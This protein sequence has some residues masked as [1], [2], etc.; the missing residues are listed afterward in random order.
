[1]LTPGK[2]R[3]RSG[4]REKVQKH[5]PDFLEYY[6]CYSFEVTECKAVRRKFLLVFDQEGFNVTIKNGLFGRSAFVPERFIDLFE[7]V[8]EKEN[9]MREAMNAHEMMVNHLNKIHPNLEEN[10]YAIESSSLG[11]IN[12]GRLRHSV[13]SIL[14]Q[15]VLFKV[16]REGKS[17]YFTNALT[18]QHIG[19]I[20]LDDAITYLGYARKIDLP[21]KNT[22]LQLT[23]EDIKF[24]LENAPEKDLN[25][26]LALRD[27]KCPLLFTVENTDW[28]SIYDQY[29][30]FVCRVYNKN[31]INRYLGV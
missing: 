17:M 7:P 5:L 27:V 25:S 31:L 6:S 2:Y 14:L 1:M 29:N 13:P 3:L 22:I 15:N 20:M 26:V 12:A 16:H 11:L 23:R 10:V 28:F 24:M 30:N 19:T 9:V 18:N 8:I 4:N 21:E